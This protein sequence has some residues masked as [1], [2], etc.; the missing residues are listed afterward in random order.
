M[1]IKTKSLERKIKSLISLKFKKTIVRFFVNS[2]TGLI[3]K[4]INKKINLYNGIFDYSLVSNHEAAS[5]FF[6]IWESA[7]IRFAKRFAKSK[8]I[9]ELGSSVGVTF[10]TLANNRDKTKFICVEPSKKNYK[11]LLKLKQSIPKKNNEYIFLNKAIYYDSP[12]VNFEDTTTV[13]SK[14]TKNNLKT[15]KS[16]KVSAVTLSQIIKKYS[17]KNQFTLISDIEG[18]EGNIFFKDVS[19]LKLCETIIVEIEKTKKY[20]IKQQ[21]LQIKKLGFC[22]VEFYNNV[23]VFSK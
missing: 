20:T 16:Y 19:S 21:I 5:I 15:I 18:A 13:T 10:G 7:E 8:I 9:I 2:F 22:A 1:L 23:F 12:N 17:V 14:I 3:I 6:G 11:K 4:K